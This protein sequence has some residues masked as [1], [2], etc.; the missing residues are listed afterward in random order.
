MANSGDTEQY[1]S[2]SQMGAKIRFHY[3]TVYHAD[4]NTSTVTL[5][6][7][8]KVDTLNNTS[9]GFHGDVY[10]EGSSIYEMSST[11]GGSYV[12]K[13]G[14]GTEW[15]AF[16]PQSGSLRTF[17]VTH[18]NSGS[19]TFTAGFIG[20]VRASYDGTEANF[21]SKKG[22]S[23][24]ITEP[25]TLHVTYDAN[26]GSGAPSDTYFY[27][28]TEDVVLSNTI[29]TRTGYT[30]AGWNTAQDGSGASYS[31]GKNIGKKTATFTLYAQWT[32]NSYTITC[33]DYFGEELLGSS[34]ASYNYGDTVSGASFG[35]STT[36]DAYHTGY[37]YTGSSE[38]ITVTGDA[39]VERYFA[40]N[41]WT[42][43][44]SPNGGSSTPNSQTK[45]YGVPL[46]L[47]ASISRSSVQIGS[48][49]VTFKY[50]NGS[51]S[52]TASSIRRQ[53]YSFGVWNTAQDGSGTSYS[54][55]GS[56]TDN[57]AVTLYAQWSS[58][59]TASAVALPAASW[60]G[61]IFKGWYAGN[62]RVG[63]A[64]DLYYPTGNITLTAGWQ[65]LTYSV[66]A[67]AS[68]NIMYVS[69]NDTESS[70]VS[71]T[72]EYGTLARFRA[73][74]NNDPAFNYSFDGWYDLY[75]QRVSTSLSYSVPVTKD[76]QLTARATAKAK[77]YILSFSQPNMGGSAMVQRVSS[78]NGNGYIG[79]LYSGSV[80]YYGDVLQVS[81]SVSPGYEVNVHTINGATF[82]SPTT[83]TVYNNVS[84]VVSMKNAGVVWVWNGSS[85]EKYIPMVWNGSAWVRYIPVVWNGSAWVIY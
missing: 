11:W 16:P 2:G 57:A 3:S 32:I 49:T 78:P 71:K 4:S 68:Q 66:V 82:T 83:I 20:I 64:G 52:T 63:G 40:L 38:E 15:K 9:I 1:I 73:A 37:H 41:T 48:Y 53:N 54:A 8:L 74:L 27:G 51:A 79:A 21:N 47:A 25:K 67:R 28:T 84:V 70:Y 77:Q 24:T 19:A 26:G 72:M 30:F 23:Q 12:L 61:H 29:P 17:D 6:P 34:T 44:Y 43:S 85:W 5:A 39:T 7:W 46:T 10:G 50:N 69:L 13:C 81:Y 56:Y 76:L 80:I 65:A 62:T 31:A 18:T 60:T 36:Y 58:H 55:L 35:D 14:N 45:T 59:T 33:N 42:V 22:I 75:N